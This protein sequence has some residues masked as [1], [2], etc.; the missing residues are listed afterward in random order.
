[1]GRLTDFLSLYSDYSTL[2]DRHMTGAIT[3]I[4]LSIMLGIPYYMN[5]Y[6]FAQHNE[7]N[8]ITKVRL[9]HPSEP[10][11]LEMATA[12]TPQ[13]LVPCQLSL[14]GDKTLPPS[15]PLIISSQD[16]WDPLSC[17]LVLPMGLLPAF[18]EFYLCLLQLKSLIL[19]CKIT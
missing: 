11:F 18:Q 17:Q 19:Y 1:M 6:A 15:I 4:V 9:T 5:C 16:N 12:A 10:S 13:S 14:P 3:Y 2:Y 7:H 8:I